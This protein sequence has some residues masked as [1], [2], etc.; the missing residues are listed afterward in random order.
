M[1]L[2][3]LLENVNIISSTASMQS[4]A[5]TVTDDSRKVG[6]GSVFVCIRG[7]NFDGHTKAQE[8]VSKG[9]CAVVTERDIGVANQIVT[10]NT[11]AAYALMCS[12]LFGNPEKQL[13]IIGVTGT[14]G[15][16]TTCFLIHDM[17][18]KMGYSCGLIGTV[19][20]II[21]KEETEATL[22]TPD[23]IQ[24]YEIF[25]KMVDA[26]C[27]YCVMEAS[28]QALAQHR[29]EGVRF[30]SAIFTN[31]T[32]DHLDYHGTFENYIAAKH[33]LFENTELA[34][35][36]FDDEAAAKMTEGISC[37]VATFSIKRD[38]ADYT[39][40]NSN[41]KSDGVEYELVSKNV[42]KRVRFRVPGEFSVYNSMGAIV[43]LTEMGLSVDKAVDA[44]ASFKS[45]P[46]RMEVV[47]TNTDYT[48]IIDYAHTPDA[49]ENVIKT[50]R[51]ISQG[52]TI[53]V[54]GCGGDRDSTK[55]PIMGKIASENAD[56]VIVTSDNP[57]TEDPE[58]I[59]DDIME[60]IQK[61]K[62]PVYR[63]A[64]RREAIAK[65]MKKAKAGDF[66]LLA[67]KGQETYQIIGHEKH[68]MDEREIVANILGGK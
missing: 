39:A 67:G 31:L 34:V 20:T 43:C 32:Q 23:P 6:A 36:N 62:I 8:A 48:V 42:I 2:S 19:K 1:Q 30:K 40:K 64:D 54:F 5:T 15:K 22:T 7:N 52:K 17:L 41:I 51:K 26:G 14:N 57:R 61:A 60:G 28:S 50:L 46:G 63:I 59:I 29:L 58:K 44:V 10:E 49:L 12:S 45:V 25:R 37:P 35:V 9:A 21:G 4:E 66:V 53:V 55:R 11:R 56:M 33:I 24:L 68:H 3:K 13:K 65:A 38:K 16:T 18:T 47:P 27:E